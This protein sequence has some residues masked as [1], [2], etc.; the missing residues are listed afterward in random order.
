MKKIILTLFAAMV[1]VVFGFAAE[2]KNY[3]F[4]EKKTQVLSTSDDDINIQSDTEKQNSFKEQ[5]APLVVDSS[6]QNHN[7]NVKNKVKDLD[8]EDENPNL[9]NIAQPAPNIQRNLR[10]PTD[11]E[12]RLNRQ[13]MLDGPKGGI[14]NSGPRGIGGSS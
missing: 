3:S 13:M 2:E 14:Q 5:Q 6:Q 1:L 9:K 7:K 4:N 8:D 11:D 10:M 12:Q